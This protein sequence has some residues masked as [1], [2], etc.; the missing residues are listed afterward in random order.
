[1]TASP[2]PAS[3]RTSKSRMLSGGGTAGGDSECREKHFNKNRDIPI[4][5]KNT[6]FSDP[7][8]VPGP[9][10][11]KIQVGNRKDRNPATTIERS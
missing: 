11:R 2:K 7:L 5:G 9:E 8:V 1:M 10:A 3:S 6:V 4:A